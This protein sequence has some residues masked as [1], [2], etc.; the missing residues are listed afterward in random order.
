LGNATQPHCVFGHWRR[1]LRSLQLTSDDAAAMSTPISDKH[2]ARSGRKALRGGNRSPGPFFPR[3]VLCVGIIS[4]LISN[5]CADERSTSGAQS[6]KSAASDRVLL[7]SEEWRRLDRAVERGLHFISESQLADGS[8]PTDPAGQPGVTSLCVMA[9]LARGHQPGKGP[10][11]SQLVKAIDYVLSIQDPEVGSIFPE[12]FVGGRTPRS[13]SGNYNHGISALMLAEVYGMTDANRHEH[14][15]QTITRALKYTRAQQLRPKRNPDDR[16]GWRYVHDFGIND[17]DLSITAWQLMFLRAAR[18]AEFH[19]PKEWINEALGYVHRSF[20]V[21]ERGF[22]Y[23]MLTDERYC[24]RG[25]VGAGIV[26]LELGGEHRSETAKEAGNWILRHSFQPYGNSSHIDDR[27]HY[28]AFYCGQAMFQLGGDY[29]HRFFPPFLKVLADA[30]HADG[31]W[32]V[33]TQRSDAIYGNVY[34]TALTVLALAPPYQLLPI[35]QR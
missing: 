1:R 3:F 15:R 2:N 25:M 31:S 14:I 12:R 20:D 9:F 13:F 27:Y 28:S 26:C 30:Q 16:G 5:A 4:G 7:S 10:H 32:D 8:F 19:V 23:A 6:A 29:W 33:D 17:S 21:N 34:T 22:V 11:G 24:S 35:Y 18:N